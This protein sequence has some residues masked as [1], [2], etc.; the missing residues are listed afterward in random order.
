[1]FSASQAIENLSKDPLLGSFT[2]KIVGEL[3]RLHHQVLA[4]AETRRQ[5]RLS[6]RRDKSQS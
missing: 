4:L 2:V 3:L 1:M 5:Q 6:Q